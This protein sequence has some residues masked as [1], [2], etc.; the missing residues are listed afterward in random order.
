MSQDP[1]KQTLGF[2]TEVR[3]LLDLMVHALYSNKEI[4]LRELI[5]NASDAAD[6]LR[7][8]A[9]GS[10]SLYEGDSQLGI[11]VRVDR[12]GR[13]VSVR[14]NGIG[15]SRQEVIEHLG[16]IAKSGTREFFQ[17]LTGDQKK[18]AQL[19]GQFGVGFYSAFIVA[20]R[21]TVLTRR[22][23]LAA[24][25]GVR[26]ESDGRGEF[27]I[28]TVERPSRGT[29]VIL[30]L[31]PEEDEFLDAF[32]LRHIIH[33]Y[34]DHITLPIR[35]PKDEGAGELETVNAATAL[36]TRPKADISDQEYEEFYKHVSHDFEAPLA[37]LHSKVE[38]KLDY[39]LLL[40]IPSRPPFDLW[41]RD[42][43]R[44]VKLYV[45]RV[46]IMEN[47]EQLMPRYLRF[48]RGVV[49]SNDLPLNISREILQHNKVIET[50]RATAVRKLLDLLEEMADKRPEDYRRFWQ[51]FGPVL[52]E[53]IVED[54]GNRDRIARLLRFASSRQADEQA[55][56]SLAEYLGRMAEGQAAIYYLTGE[57][58]ATLRGS[59]HLEVFRERDLEVLLLDDPVD[60]WLVAHLTEFE[61]K[62]L[63]SVSRGQLDLGAVEGEAG[64]PE[65][66]TG[67][68]LGS[69]SERIHEVLK[70]RVKAV[71]VSQRL[72]ES[73]A[74]LVREE[75]ELG[76]HLEQML[77]AAGQEPPSVQPT[78][79]I[80]PRHPVV[81]RL[82]A[83]QEPERFRDWA[84]IL[85]DQAL[86]SE[87]GRPEDPAA[88]VRR[89]NQMF[90]AL[91]GAPTAG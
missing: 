58:Q 47:A 32:R 25:Q 18:D 8:E 63:K 51:A 35:M 78:L 65:A 67:A 87:G 83:E 70:D 24:D 73:P 42:S 66:E 62:P 13:T 12:K 40:F 10:E 4:F 27:S 37:R 91:G 14:D 88:F 79:E 5:S 29:E 36:W 21:V 53:G 34:S 55:Q 1:N 7:F 3:Q 9:L 6:K 31:R 52:K 90:V 76:R 2:Q 56:V 49:D 71:R 41:D 16:T 60:E 50:I 22:A 89:L 39:T 59:P 30:H 15:M 28:E 57:S 86:L 68:A 61:N 74:C 23:G 84:W 46:F 77:R 43:R 69:L 20:D 33:R 26:W 54:S 64:K 81:L 38:G 82:A 11:E 72:T 80:N 48:V 19:I 85:L 17:A 45:R 75:G 44:G